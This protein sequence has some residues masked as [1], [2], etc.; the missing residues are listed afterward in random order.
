MAGAACAMLVIVAGVEPVLYIWTIRA[1]VAQLT[2]MVP[3]SSSLGTMSKV[4]SAPVP[5]R[6]TR[7]KGDVF[8]EMENSTA[9]VWLPTACGLSLGGQRENTAS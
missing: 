5:D 6:A 3:K 1:R 7:L 2:P 9:P 8:D 4:A